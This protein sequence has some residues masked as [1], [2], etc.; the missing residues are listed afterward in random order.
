MLGPLTVTNSPY[1]GGADGCS[2]TG[3]CSG[4]G[5]VFTAPMRL[6]S[7][8]MPGAHGVPFCIDTLPL[9]SVHL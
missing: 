9:A 3:F 8:F 6:I 7:C 2:A 1:T 4:T 5:T